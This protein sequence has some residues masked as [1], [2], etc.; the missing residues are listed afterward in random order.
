M[1]IHC[2]SLSK[3][4]LC[5]VEGSEVTLYIMHSI[6]GSFQKHRYSSKGYVVSY[7][8]TLS[9]CKERHVNCPIKQPYKDPRHLCFQVTHKKHRFSSKFHFIKFLDQDK[10][11]SGQEEVSYSSSFL[12]LRKPLD[13]PETKISLDLSPSG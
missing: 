5:K 6:L 1:R 11:L 10:P 13:R 3:L 12:F 8:V 9:A 4:F 2:V 7:F